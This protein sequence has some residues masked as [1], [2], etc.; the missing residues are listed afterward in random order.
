MSFWLKLY[1]S[2]PSC[3]YFAGL[4]AP[5]K[6]PSKEHWKSAWNVYFGNFR[7][8][9]WNFR[10]S[11]SKI[12]RFQFW[13]FWFEFV[14]LPT[15]MINLGKIGPFSFIYPLTFADS[16]PSLQFCMVYHWTPYFF[17][18]FT[19][20]CLSIKRDAMRFTN[21]FTKWIDVPLFQLRWNRS[22][23]FTTM[24]VQGVR[25]NL[26]NV[27]KNYSD[28]Q[29]KVREATSNDPWGPS[30][31]LMSEVA[32]LTYNVV[33]F[34][35]IMQLVW[36]RLNDHGKNWRHVYKALVLL[37]YLIKTGSERVSIILWNFAYV[38]DYRIVHFVSIISGSAT[39]QGKYICNSDAKG[40]STRRG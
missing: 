16:D 28:A 19:D 24:N 1:T 12:N 25:R 31:T 40:F 9:I 3:V 23:C 26:K 32:D 27:V 5:W 20:F 29:V 36:K 8:K 14:E 38:V 11:F 35:E 22:S 15:C 17:P 39:V 4:E 18:N 7:L 10:F 21:Q 37:E 13:A 6:T 30:S 34:S 33:A 2:I